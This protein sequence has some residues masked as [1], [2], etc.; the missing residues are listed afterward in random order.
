MSC[1][2]IFRRD[3]R[4]VDNLALLEATR[5]YEK[6]IPCFIFTPEQ[7]TEKNPYRSTNAIQFMC[8]SL[9]ELDSELRT[10]NSKL[11]YFQGENIKVLDSIHQDF[12]KTGEK[13]DAI[14][15][16]QDYTPYAKK[17]DQEIQKWCQSQEIKC[18]IAEDYLLA[19]V[20][21][22]V[23]GDG[24]PYTVFTPFKNAGFKIT[25]PKIN[26][27]LAANFGKF[28]FTQMLDKIIS[29]QKNE[30]ILVSGGRKLGKKQIKKLKNQNQYNTTRNSLSL[31]T[32]H[33]SAYIKFGCVSIR[34][35]Y[36]KI[37]KLYGMQNNLLDQLFWREFY[38]YIAHYFPQVLQGKNYNSKYDKIKWTVNKTNFEKWC[39]GE[40]GYPVVDAG[41]RQLN[42]TGYMHNR[43]R[44]ITSNFLN[45]MLGMDWRLG[46][47]Y[48][49]QKLTDYDPSVNN[50]NWQ[51]IA[52]TGTDPKPYFQRLFNPILQSQKF[53][54]D[55]SYIKKWLPEL[56]QIPAKE[57]HDWSKFYQNYN[58]DEINYVAPVVE[59]KDARK[60]SVEMYRK[61]LK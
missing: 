20:G 33:L 50:G 18:V 10:R 49:A 17:R 45:R 32:S 26:L 19:P 30:N 13:L 39:L 7:I 28:N 24:N 51:W 21:T 2:F 31:E 55:A 6:V 25:V 34:E 48:F 44:L 12:K 38:F 52:S 61:V 57:L 56:S 47:K 1:L 23:K 36:H 41:M 14:V 35:V 40:T 5:N 29:Y 9:E 46:E 27:K 37:K 42:T 43:A 54:G 15:F 59:Y 3:L 22:I 53:D 58:L 16:N 8:E 60:A 4:L 11:H